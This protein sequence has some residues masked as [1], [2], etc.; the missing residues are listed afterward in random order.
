MMFL[1]RPELPTAS[2]GSS[3]APTAAVDNSGRTKDF[4]L[5][6]LLQ[7]RQSCEVRFV[8]RESI[9]ARSRACAGAVV[10]RVYTQPR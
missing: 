5:R 6:G 7:L 2:A 8:W 9:K 4:I 1:V 10:K 3:Q